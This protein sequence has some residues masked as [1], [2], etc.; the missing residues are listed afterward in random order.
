MDLKEIVW[1]SVGWIHLA[2]YMYQW[3]ALVNTVIN[4]RTSYKAKNFLTV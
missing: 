4:L 2:Y 1:E 3:Q